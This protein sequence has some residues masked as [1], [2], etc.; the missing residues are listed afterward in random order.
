[1]TGGRP[2]LVLDIGGVLMTDLT[3]SFWRWV[4]VRA[5]A[6]YDSVLTWFHQDVRLALWTGAITEG[7]FWTQLGSRFPTGDA[8]AA[9][10]ALRASLQ[11]LPALLH[12]ADWGQVAD[13]H[14]LSNQRKEWLGPV[15]SAAK[16]HVRSVTISSVVGC[17]KPHPTIYAVVAGKLRPDAMTLF[18]DD[19]YENLMPARALGWQTVYADLQGLWMQTVWSLLSHAKEETLGDVPAPGEMLANRPPLS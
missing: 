4:A 17:C 5:D 15:L 2:Q 9:R 8:A 7:Q 11:P 19:H 13:I 12:L 1:V 18:V 14:L 16:A 10:A 3:P 6:P